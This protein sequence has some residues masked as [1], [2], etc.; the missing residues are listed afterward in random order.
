VLIAA[1]VV[2]RPA[3]DFGGVDYRKRLSNFIVDRGR[4]PGGSAT[5]T[6]T[7]RTSAAP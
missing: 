7:A 1:K 4:T 3:R 6:A 5:T 2:D